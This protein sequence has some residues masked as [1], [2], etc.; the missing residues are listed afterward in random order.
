MISS[1]NVEFLKCV[2]SYAAIKIIFNVDSITSYLFLLW[3][4]ISDTSNQVDIN[5]SLYIIRLLYC[6]YRKLTSLCLSIRET[7]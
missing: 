3:N 2:F 7:I 1:K 4:V 5:V 6:N